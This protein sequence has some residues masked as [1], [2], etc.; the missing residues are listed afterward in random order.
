[1]HAM[2][3]RPQG[4]GSV[5]VP[6]GGV[7]EDLPLPLEQDP[8]EIHTYTR[9]KLTKP[10]GA[11]GKGGTRLCIQKGDYLAFTTSGGFGGFA[12]DNPEQ[13][14]VD[15]AEFQVFGPSR[16]TTSFLRQGGAFT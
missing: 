2:V 7:S 1:M 6:P 13:I 15:G 16:T 3:L 8:N 11:D 12:Q 9:A 10:D 5:A 4:D 14:Y